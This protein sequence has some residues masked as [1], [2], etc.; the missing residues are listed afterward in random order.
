ST[1]LSVMHA[2]LRVLREL[3]DSSRSEAAQVRVS[4][5]VSEAAAFAGRLAFDLGDYAAFQRHYR[6]AIQHAERSGDQ[7]LNAYMIGSLGYWSVIA[8]DGEGRA[9]HLVE[10]ARSLLPNHVPGIVEPWLAVFEASAHSIVGNVSQVL[11]A[12]GR[13][14]EAV[15]RD[16]E[17]WPWTGPLD[18]GRLMELRGFWAARLR[19]PD[20]S[21]PALHEGLQSLGP[22]PSKWRGLALAD[23]SEGYVLKEEIEE[24]CR[25]AG[26]AFSIGVELHSDRVVRRVATVRA[27]LAPWKDTQAVRELG[28]RMV[29]GFDGGF[30]GSKA[31]ADSPCLPFTTGEEAPKGYGKPS[32]QHSVI[33]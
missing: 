17:P 32:V 31:R 23:L 11:S 5:A 21:L 8:G 2:H 18:P 20:I 12:L 19:L 14:E 16:R 15:G 33:S 30:V 22:E 6:S 4:A 1:L 10:R 7:L 26:E 9:M 28:E 24:A 3:L 25:W 27:Q 29:E 13:A